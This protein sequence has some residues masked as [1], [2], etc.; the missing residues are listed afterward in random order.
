MGDIIVIRRIHSPQFS[1]DGG[2]CPVCLIL[3]AG[4]QETS[5]YGLHRDA[6]SLCNL[7]A[8]YS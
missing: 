3:I 2:N 5:K 8:N 1:H 6:Q 4:S 7:F